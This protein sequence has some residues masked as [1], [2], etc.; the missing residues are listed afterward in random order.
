MG[1]MRLGKAKP[2]WLETV[3][4]LY[5]P[6]TFSV[7]KELQGRGGPTRPPKIVFPED[8]YRRRFFAQHSMEQCRPTVLDE[9]VPDK[10]G[11]DTYCLRGGGYGCMFNF[12]HSSNSCYRVFTEQTRL[13]E[14]EGLSANEAYKSAVDQ[15]RRRRRREELAQR[16]AQEQFMEV[17]TVPSSHVIEEMILEERKIMSSNGGESQVRQ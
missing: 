6:V 2:I 14:E 8:S 15:Y 4:K 16:V 3:S 10:G 7:P 9:R 11:P 1:V 12:F 17:A 5:P 13:M